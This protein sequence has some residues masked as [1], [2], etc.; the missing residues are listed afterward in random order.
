M[1]INHYKCTCDGCG[2]ERLLVDR[3]SF[4]INAGYDWEDTVEYTTCWKCKLE[5]KLLSAKT[6]L[7]DFVSQFVFALTAATL[8]SHK[9]FSIP[10]RY[11]LFKVL[12]TIQPH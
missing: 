4:V 6:N 1:R 2:K 9:P 10:K 7:K 3:V 11:K 5:G 12:M 8:H